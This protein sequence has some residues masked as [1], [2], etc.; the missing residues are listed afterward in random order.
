MIDDYSVIDHNSV[1]FFQMVTHLVIN[2]VQQGLTVVAF[3][4][5]F[6]SFI[7]TYGEFDMR[8]LRGT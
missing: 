6:L 5:L 7:R 2:P 1:K 4:D 3:N 8:I